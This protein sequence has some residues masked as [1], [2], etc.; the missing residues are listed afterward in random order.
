MSSHPPWT[1]W[2]QASWPMTVA[3]TAAPGFSGEASGSGGASAAAPSAGGVP[4]GMDSSIG[5]DCAFEE[6]LMPVVLQ[7]LDGLRCVV[8]EAGIVDFVKRHRP[9]VL[10]QLGDIVGVE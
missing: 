5:P 2:C 3:G 10:A 7:H 9:R 8:F 6:N 1:R 4:S